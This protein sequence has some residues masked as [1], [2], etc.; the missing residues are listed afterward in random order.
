VSGYTADNLLTGDTLSSVNWA[1]NS[2]VDF[3]TEH[4]PGQGLGDCSFYLS[5]ES[6][7]EIHNIQ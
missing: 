5:D 3:D 6:L 4:R 2:S 1:D 7:K